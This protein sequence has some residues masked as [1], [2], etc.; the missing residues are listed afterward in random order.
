MK[1]ASSAR[2]LASFILF[3]LRFESRFE[4]WLEE[5]KNCVLKKISISQKK[6]YVVKTRK[7]IYM[8]SVILLLP[9]LS[10]N[11]IAP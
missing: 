2:F 4:F 8:F 6:I 3:N 11:Q 9:A 10:M 7:K 1:K 5:C